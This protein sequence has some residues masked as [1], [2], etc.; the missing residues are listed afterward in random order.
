MD[1][2]E[3]ASRRGAELDS[4]SNENIGFGPYYPS[5]SG[6]DVA[7]P[8]CFDADSR[9]SWLRKG[10]ESLEEYI[11]VLEK[12]TWRNIGLEQWKIDAME[13]ELSTWKDILKNEA[14][15]I[16][17]VK[18]S[19]LRSVTVCMA[20][21]QPQ[22]ISWLWPGRIALG[23][24]T[25]I[26][27]DPGLGKS[28]LTVTMAAIVSKGQAW[29][30]NGPPAPI[31]S[32]VLLSAE[33]DPADTIRPR[34]DAAMADCA[35]IHVLQAIRDTDDED[36]PIQRLFSFKRDIQR[37][38][39][40]LPTLPNCR[41]LIIDPVSAYLDGTESHNNGDIRGLL[42]PLADLAARHGVA[43]VLVQHLNKNSGTSA[44]YRSMG[45]I[46]FIAA[47]RAAYIVTKDRNNPDRRLV[48]PVKNNL[49][50]DDTGLAYSVLTAE[51]EA[52]VIQWEEEPVIM[53]ADEALTPADSEEEKTGTDWAVEVLEIVL[54]DGPIS[55]TSVHKEAKQANISP[56]ALRRA[57]ERLGIKP[58]KV[59]YE[60][61]WVW[62]L[63]G[64]EGALSS[65][66]APTQNEGTLGAGGHLGD[67]GEL[68]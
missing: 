32:V 53:T 41:L 11:R 36:A 61:G 14:E 65:E 48:M 19:P 16:E 66:G 18:T 22:P 67:V 46:A 42:A 39:E 27:G 64:H 43:V 17:R 51:N 59:G 24:I 68:L 9:D 60:G 49:A 26:A 62:M 23:K 21:V 28:L 5:H 15:E 3:S 20:D 54:K 8:G 6:Y 2:S 29:P 37:L 44:M 47:A 34:L 31:G 45:S 38:E 52:P 35:R 58:R 40:L 30:L 55:S 10:Y 33:D 13:R 4:E 1:I 12:G 57:Q 50:R 63:P 7:A 25:L 56:K